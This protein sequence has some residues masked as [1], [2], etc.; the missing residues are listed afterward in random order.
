[1]LLYEPNPVWPATSLEI[2]PW[3]NSLHIFQQDFEI[4][5]LEHCCTV[6]VYHEL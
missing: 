5:I 1:M 3:I 6:M 2:R 4:R